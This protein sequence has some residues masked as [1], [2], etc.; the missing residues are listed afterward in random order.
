LN[1]LSFVLVLLLAS[2]MLGCVPLD[3]LNPW[4][5]QK[6]VVFDAALLGQWGTNDEGINFAKE[7][8]GSYAMSWT[9]RSDNGQLVSYPASAHLVN[10]QGHLFLDVV[11]A[12]MVTAYDATTI[13]LERNKN[14]VSPSP[15]LIRIGPS[16]YLEIANGRS[17]VSSDQLAVRIRQAHQFF[18]VEFAD[19]QKSINLIPLDD[20]WVTDQVA[21]GKIVIDHE[22]V[23]DEMRSMVLTADTPALQKLVLEHVNDPEVFTGATTVRRPGFENDA[24][25]D[26]LTLPIK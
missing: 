6:D 14:G 7:D 13:K 4:Y 18:K 24:K 8:D 3:S 21:N 5:T 10:L 26:G 11:N 1:K 12:P 17:E 19:E 20:K 2:F 9:G 15:G 25:A 22:M 23:G 16:S